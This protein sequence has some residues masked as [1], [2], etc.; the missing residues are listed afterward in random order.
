MSYQCRNCRA[1]FEEPLIKSERHGFTY[2]PYET[3]EVCPSCRVSGMFSEL[4]EE[5]EELLETA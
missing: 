5:D 3:V 4:E 1:V 2:G